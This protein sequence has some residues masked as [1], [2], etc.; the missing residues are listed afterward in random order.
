MEPLTSS[1]ILVLLGAG[2]VTAF[3]MLSVF[4]NAIGHE[5]QLHDLRNRVKELNYQQAMYQAKVSGQISEEGEVEIID[6]EEEII[7][8]AEEVPEPTPKAQ[9]LPEPLEESVA[10]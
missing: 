3:A 8:V 2:A 10:A 1:M 7:E 5:T 4:A 9:S 6:D